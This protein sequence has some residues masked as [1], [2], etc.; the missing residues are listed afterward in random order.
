MKAL[1]KIVLHVDAS[2]ETQRALRGVIRLSILSGATIIAVHVVNRAVVT[3]MA[4]ATGKSLA[5]VEVELEEDGWRYLYAT[6][7]TAKSAGAH[8][9]IVQE[10]GYPEEV[11][12]RLASEY[13]ADILALGAAARLRH[14][15]IISRLI[16]QVI[17]TTPCSVLV[18][19]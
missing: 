18:V 12:P 3:Q 10:Q 11:L 5:E 13:G 4:R 19:K 17:E 16:E 7:E 15:S 9:V 1:E 14:D 8:I 2:E 6:E